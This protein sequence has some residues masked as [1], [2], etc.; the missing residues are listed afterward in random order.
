LLPTCP[1]ASSRTAFLFLGHRLADGFRVERVPGGDSEKQPSSTFHH[2]GNNPPRSGLWDHRNEFYRPIQVRF[3]CENLSRLRFRKPD[4][5]AVIHG[6][7]LHVGKF[8]QDMA[9]FQF[10]PHEQGRPV[11]PGGTPS[12]RN[13]IPQGKVTARQS[14]ARF[15]RMLSTPGHRFWPGAGHNLEDVLV[16]CSSLR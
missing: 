6:Q 12:S 13:S 4:S 9:Q 8:P 1:N 3:V 10:I 11:K 5:L 2:F 7:C 14:L 16:F 15:P